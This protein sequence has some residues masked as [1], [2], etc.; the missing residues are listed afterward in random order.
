MPYRK[1]T[2]KI[3][4]RYPRKKLGLNKVEKKQVKQILNKNIESKFLDIASDDASVINTSDNTTAM[5]TFRNIA[6]G[7]GE[8]ERIGNSVRHKGIAYNH[9][10][11][12]TLPCFVRHLILMAPTASLNSDLD[13]AFNGSNMEVN[14]FLPRETSKYKILKDKVY[15]LQPSFSATGQA[16][17]QLK[18]YINLK[19]KKQIYDGDTAS[20]AQSFF[21]QEF[22]YTDN[23]TASSLSRNGNIR[24][25]YKDG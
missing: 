4:K 14:T 18:G 24:S 13:T 21:I 7:D 5:N 10:L 9:L 17:K 1:T 22:F 19:G 2:R 8:S 20:D 12:S 15:K 6:Q 11:T 25:Y 3:M 16:K 23:S